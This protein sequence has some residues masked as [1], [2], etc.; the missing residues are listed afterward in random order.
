VLQSFACVFIRV[1]YEHVTFTREPWGIAGEPSALFGRNISHTP[2]S[3]CSNISCKTVLDQ[4]SRK[5]QNNNRA[6]HAP[7][8]II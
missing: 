7:T 1:N 8:S 5:E 6:K 4:N 3:F 2:K